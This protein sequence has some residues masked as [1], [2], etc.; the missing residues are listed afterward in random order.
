MSKSTSR[1]RSRYVSLSAAALLACFAIALAVL[2]SRS[3]EAVSTGNV[4]QVHD[5]A[6]NFGTIVT[7]NFI[8]PL[9]LFNPPVPDVLA[10]WSFEG[11]TTTGTGTTP[12]ITGSAVAD[13][14]V[15]TPG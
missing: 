2:P 8:E 3:A 14:G 9:N 6:G 10:A 7:N 13:S 15:L 4:R 5:R 11:V 1:S 12:V